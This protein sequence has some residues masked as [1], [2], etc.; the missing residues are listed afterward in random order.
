M[1]WLPTILLGT[2]LLLLVGASVWLAKEADGRMPAHLAQ[3]I[4]HM[5]GGLY[6]LE[7][8]RV[9]SMP[10]GRQIEF[11][12]VRIV[13]DTARF[14]ELQAVDSIP[15]RLFAIRM[16]TLRLTGIRWEDWWLD[17]AFYCKEVILGGLT[18]TVES[19]LGKTPFQLRTPQNKLQLAGITL[20]NLRAENMDFFFLHH[21]GRVL[22]CAS[23]RDGLLQGN[24]IRWALRGFPAYEDL[25]LT[26]GAT[27]LQLPDSRNEY[28]AAGWQID[29]R[30]QVFRMNGFRFR[31]RP[32]DSLATTRHQLDI[33]LL[34]A[35]GLRKLTDTP[36]DFF[37]LQH[38]KLYAPYVTAFVNRQRGV[39]MSTT[40][41]DFP[42]RLLQKAGLPLW[43][44]QT[45]I[46][47]GAVTYEETEP[48]TGRTG[49]VTFT[50]LSGKIQSL[51]LAMPPPGHRPDPITVALNGHLQNRSLITVRA[52]LDMR[53]SLQRFVLSGKISRMQGTQ[54]SELAASLGKLRILRL[55]LDSMQFQ[56]R[57]NT[58]VIRNTLRLAYHDLSVQLLR[59]DTVQKSMRQQPMLSML[60]NQL[61][62]H[63]ANPLA[64]QALRV[65]QTEYIRPQTQPFFGT[66]WRSLFENI[67]ETVIADPVLLEY[68]RQKAATRQQRKDD[69]LRRREERKQRRQGRNDGLLF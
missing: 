30:E 32:S 20:E 51:W 60:A 12:D 7:S 15:D 68:V 57:G 36:G 53:D 2:V 48:V 49:V 28:A 14:R 5:T 27:D 54:I 69:R 1:L 62:L 55:Q 29:F 4:R 38:L 65:A 19:G 21:V 31:E 33:A 37:A 43:I 47:Q 16:K 41:K 23:S 6:R 9:R 17:Q 50:E 52:K 3:S 58:Q 18:V 25:T 64:G 61:L 67:K 10:L 22:I 63:P 8:G 11:S 39:P 46:T 24:H 35:R 13:L 44:E 42:Q 56:Y 59:Y 40:P 66:L 26:L 34:E 45:S